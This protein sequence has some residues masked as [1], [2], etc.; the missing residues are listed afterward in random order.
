MQTRTSSHLKGVDVSSHQGVIDWNKMKAAGVQ[1]AILRA[2]GSNHSTGG[3]TRMA[4]YVAGARAVGIPVG[5][6]FF[7]WINNPDDYV[8]ARRQANLYVDKLESVFGAGKWGDLYPFIDL[9]GNENV[10]QN[11]IYG[12]HSSLDTTKMLRWV[13]EFRKQFESRLNV[14]LGIY[15]SHYF[16]YGYHKH[17]NEGVT[18]E[19]NILKNMPL[20]IA[21]WTSSTTITDAGGWTKWVLWQ[22]S[23]SGDAYG[24]GIAHGAQSSGLDIDVG[25]PLEYL[26]PPLPPSNAVG[27]L[28]DNKYVTLTWTKSPDNDIISYHI[29]RNGTKIGTVSGTTTSFTDNAISPNVSYSYY[30]QA[31]DEY[32]GFASSNTV[33]IQA[34]DVP[35]SV[36]TGLTVT[37]KDREI[38]FRWTANT[39]T[40][41]KQYNLYMGG[42]FIAS[43]PDTTYTKTGLTNGVV[44]SFQVEAERANGKKS[45]LSAAVQG[46]PVLDVPTKVTNVNASVQTDK[47]IL[48]TWED[49]PKANWSH[50]Q[51][52]VNNKIVAN[53]ISDT[54]FKASGLTENATLS[55]QV[56]SVD[57]QGDTTVSDTVTSI[58]EVPAT[59]TGFVATSGDRQITITW[60]AN[61][62]TFFRRYNIYLDNTLLASTTNTSYTLSNLVNGRTYTFAVAAESLSGVSSNRTLPI[63]ATP[64]A[65][66][67]KQPYQVKA[68]VESASVMVLSWKDEPKADFSHYRIYKNDMLLADNVTVK[69][70]RDTGI[71][72]PDVT[73]SYVVS[74]VD[75]DGDENKSTPVTAIIHVPA[76]PTELVATPYDREISLSWKSSTDNWFS[77]Y[78]VYVNGELYRTITDHAITIEELTNDVV[79][80]FKVEA[81][82]ETGIV[83][84]PS[85]IVSAIPK[86]DVPNKPTI[87]SYETTGIGGVELIWEHEQKSPFEHYRV[88]QNGNILEDYITTKSYATPPLEPDV[89]HTFHVETIDKHGDVSGWSDSVRAIVYS[90]EALSGGDRPLRLGEIDRS[91]LPIEPHLYLCKP[92]KTTIASLVEAYNIELTTK[93]ADLNEIS[94]SLPYYIDKGTGTKRNP[95]IDAIRERFLLKLVLGDKTE[96]FI[97]TQISDQSDESDTKEIRAWS[98][99]YELRDKVIRNLKIDEPF[100]AKMAMETALTDVLNWSIGENILNSNFN[101]NRETRV[102]DVSS[103]T[104]L[105][106]VKQ[107]AESYHATIVWDTVNRIID[108]KNP[109]LEDENK[110]LTFS[111][112]KYLR[113]LGLQRSSEDMVT[114]LTP[115]GAEGITIQEANPTGSLFLENFSHFLFPFERDV[116]RNIIQS[117]NYMSDSLAH[118]ILDYQALLETHEGEYKTL[119]RDKSIK[120]ADITDKEIELDEATNELVIAQDL[121]DALKAQNELMYYDVAY[122]GVT[123]TFTTQLKDAYHYVVIGKVVNPTN[124]T[125]SIDDVAKTITADTWTVLAKLEKPATVPTDSWATEIT[126]SGTGSTSVEVQVN[127]ILATEYTDLTDDELLDKYSEEIHQREVDTLTNELNTLKIELTDI[128]LQIQS[129]VSTLSIEN[130]FT[131]AQR[132]ERDLFV[133][134]KDWTN[135]SLATSEEL[136]EAAKK[137]FEK[138]LEPQIV[139]QINVVNFLNVLEHQ[140]D[141]KKLVLGDIVTIKHDILGLEPTKAK[142][143]EITYSFDNNDIQLTI[144]NV[145]DIRNDEQKFI[146]SLYGAISTS[147]TVDVEKYKWSKAEENAIALDN[148]FNQAIDATKQKIIAGVNETV[149]ISNRGLLIRDKDDPNNYLVGQHAVLA[150]TNDGGKTFKNAITT[151]GVIGERIIGEILAGDNLIIKN[152]SGTFTVDANGVTVDGSAFNI[153]GG[154]SNDKLGLDWSGLRS[155]YVNYTDENNKIS[156]PVTVPTVPADSI[157]HT[158]NADGSVNISFQWNFDDTDEQAGSIDGFMIYIHQSTSSASYSFG[159]A[160]SREVVYNVS[161]SKRSIILKN[162][163]KQVYYTFGVESYRTVDTTVN[164]SGVI[165]S[166]IVKS[167][168]VAENPYNPSLSTAFTGD[169]EGTIPSVVTNTNVTDSPLRYVQLGADYN[170]VKIDANAGIVVT[171]S[172]GKLRTILNATDGIAI[173]QYVNNAWTNKFFADA[174]GQLYSR[175]LVA[176]RLQIKDQ[177]G[178]VL[179]DANASKINFGSFGSHTGTVKGTNL[180]LKGNTVN[181][182]TADTFKVD[183]NGNV[184]IR[185]NITMEGGSITWA[186]ITAPSYTQVTG[187]KPPTDANNTYKELNPA[188]QTSAIKGFYFNAATNQLEINADYITVGSV[189]DNR[190]ASASSWNSAVTTINNM[191]NDDKLTPVEKQTIKRQWATIVA[192]KPNYVT[193]AT[194]Y[195]VSSTAYVNAYNTLDSLLNNTTNGYLLNM[196]TT[197]DLGVGGG[198]TFRDKFDDYYATL[199]ALTK[200]INEEAKELAD[201]AQ[202]TASSAQSAASSAQGTA[203]TASSNASSALTKIDVIQKINNVATGGILTAELIK[204]T[205]Y[206]GSLNAGEIQIKAVAEDIFVHPDGT[207]YPIQTGKDI[208]TMYEGTSTETEGYIMFVGSDEARFTIT[209]VGSTKQFVVTKFSNGNWY[210]DNNS[211]S[212][213]VFTVTEKDCIVGKIIRTATS[214]GIDTL[215]LF[216]GRNVATKDAVESAQSTASSAQSTASSA[217][218]TANTAIENA[219][220]AQSTANTAIGDASTAQE[221]ANNALGEIAVIQKLYNVVMGGIYTGEFIKNT[222]YNGTANAGEIQIKIDAE[223]LFVHPDGTEYAIAINK[224]IS[225]HLEGTG[226]AEEAYIMFTGYDETRFT[227]GTTVASKQFVLAKYIDDMWHYDDNSTTWRQFT[228]TDKDCIVAKVLKS[229][230]SAEIDSIVLYA[231]RNVATKTAVASVKETAEGAHEKIDNLEVGG[232]NYIRDADFKDFSTT[233]W[234]SSPNVTKDETVL[235]QGYPT[236]KSA[237]S[238]L[239]APA[240][241]GL[242]QYVPFEIGKEYTFSVYIMT[243]NYTAIDVPSNIQIICENPDGSVLQMFEAPIDFA[244]NGGNNVWVRF[245][246]TALIPV[247]TSKVR[248]NARVYQNGTMWFALPQYELGNKMTDWTLA[249]EDVTARLDAVKETAESAEST[250]STVNTTVTNNQ[251]TWDRAANFNTNGT[252]NTTKLSGTVSDNQVASA[253]TWHSKETPEGAQAKVDAL[254]IGGRNLITNSTVNKKTDGTADLTNWS[255]FNTGASALTTATGRLDDFSAQITASQAQ[256]GVRTPE[257]TK[258]MGGEEYVASVWIKQSTAGSVGFL[259]KF[260]DANGAETNPIPTATVTCNANEWVRVVQI[261]TMPTTA[262][263]CDLTARTIT[264]TYPV[265]L[266]VDDAQIEKGNKVTDWTLSIEDVN[267]SIATAESNAK[268]YTD[269]LSTKGLGLKVNYS[270]FATTNAGELYVH[271]FDSNGNPADVDGYLIVNGEKMTVP[272]GQINPNSAIGEAYITYS[273]GSNKWMLSYVDANKVWKYVYADGTNLGTIFT[274]NDSHY[275]V[276]VADVTGAETIASATLWIDYKTH[277]EMASVAEAKYSNST[278][279]SNKG[280]WDR[281]TNINAD[282]TFNT[283]KLSG[284]VSDAQIAS[285]A[286]WNAKETTSGAQAKADQARK[287]ALEAGLMTKNPLFFDWSGNYPVGMVAWSTG[288]GQKETVITRNGGNALRFV[289]TGTEDAGARYKDLYKANLANVKYVVV[290]FDFYVVS[291]TDLSAAGFLIDWAGMSPYRVMMNLPSIYSNIEIGKW[292]SVRRVIQRPTDTLT[293]F[294]SMDGYLMAS[295]TTLGTKAPK[296]IVYDRFLVREATNEEIKAYESANTLTLL[297]TTEN[298]VT[299]IDG[300]KIKT[301][302]VDVNVIKAGQ[303]HV[304][305]VGTNINGIVA[306]GSI[307]ADIKINT[308]YANT[309]NAGEIY[310][311]KG[312]YIAPNGQI[313]YFTGGTTE[314]DGEVSTLFEGATADSVGIGYLAYVGSDMSR[315]VM[316]SGYSNTKL[317]ILRPNGTEWQYQNNSTW[318]SFVPNANDFIIAR[319]ERDAIVSNGIDRIYFYASIAND[320]GELLDYATGETL[321]I[322]GKLTNNSIETDHLQAS[323]VTVE[324]LD[325]RARD[326]INNPSRTETLTGWYPIN[327]T[328]GATLTLADNVDRN[329]KVMKLTSTDRIDAI[330][331]YFEVD[332]LDT[333]KFTAS[334]YHPNTTGATQVRFYCY[335]KNKAALSTKYYDGVTRAYVASST[336]AWTYYRTGA[337]SETDTLGLFRPVELYLIGTDVDPI[338]TPTGIN[339]GRIIQ[340]PSNAKFVRI[341]VVNYNNGGVSGD[342][343]VHSPTMKKVDAGIFTFD[344]AKGGTLSLGGTNN[345]NGV[346]EVLSPDGD[347]QVTLAGDTGGF[348]SLFIGEIRG[349]NVVTRNNK[350]ALTY[351]VDPV[352]G[353]DTNTGTDTSPFKTMQA[354]IN[355]IP[356]VNDDD[357]NIQVLGTGITFVESLVI[358]GILGSGRILISLGQSNKMKGEISVL[359]CMNEVNIATRQSSNVSTANT[360]TLRAEIINQNVTNGT[361]YAHTCQAVIAN[362]IVMNGNNLIAYGI[363]AIRSY[364]RATYCECYNATAGGAIAQFGSRLEIENCAGSN[365]KGILVAHSSVAGG[366][367]RGFY[368]ASTG[369]VTVTQGGTCSATWTHDAGASKPTYAPITTSTWTANKTYSYNA[370]TGWAS[371]YVYQGKRPGDIPIWYG[372]FFFDTASF[373]VLKNA[374]GTA[375]PI[376]SVRV[377]IQRTSNTGDNTARKPKFY[378]NMQTTASGSVQTLQTSGT[379]AAESFLWGEEKWVVL[380][381]SFGTA[382]QNGTAKSLVIYYGSDEA[383]YMRFEAKATLEI[384]HG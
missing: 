201:T 203:N 124:V 154:V 133:I 381:T 26:R 339:Q 248:I 346:L 250:A 2:Y 334:L 179:I 161:R 78:R 241:R 352:A 360:S 115:Y 260:R 289:T 76:K 81:V 213:T 231:S 195:G 208:T 120:Q 94:F 226:F 22:I 85:D 209:T 142:I 365:P 44:Y 185:G 225:T 177:N 269:K 253:T 372:F 56:A 295:Y 333:Y 59:P 350:G 143:I 156:V 21:R 68:I 347:K 307:L 210:Y 310:I 39:E 15:T 325:V 157:D 116:N 234:S 216:A 186:N 11:G 318:L 72:E 259:L 359:Y 139:I 31:E 319:I 163:P 230:T 29:Y 320:L 87:V 27:T 107:I 244:N 217:Q 123:Q 62:E 37:A 153:I 149:E 38:E 328:T 272:K 131:E 305:N 277:I 249:I 383:N 145:E 95:N 118:A 182:G 376:N 89:Q 52:I 20:W 211:G 50:Y 57:T 28:K 335:D 235:F 275:F 294:T 375:R 317:A 368:G 206:D 245:V 357:I 284:T 100:T 61:L 263:E 257:A 54:T 34:V 90:A 229:A 286:T 240:Y 239:A 108:F 256:A 366:S 69:T 36:P 18:A 111:Y 84:E 254:E 40:D 283:T 222:T 48:I 106:F 136:Y 16:I 214:S 70:Y 374:D 148:F 336:S 268:T 341:A 92:N 192:E 12:K 103:Q 315:I 122:A 299:V 10:S 308:S 119:Q 127:R 151:T 369:H 187:T 172:S 290:E 255:L 165:K 17:F 323:A 355:V 196:A 193:L 25:M 238:G 212:W 60:N 273:K 302:S 175:D 258:L 252:L 285:A 337:T 43:T 329:A 384:V 342:T 246:V 287:E 135:S 220:T 184:T 91:L 362:D 132:K 373:S 3:D 58:I 198:A 42:T 223:D 86:L 167:A 181:N 8:E 45:A 205:R 288:K 134:N 117:S 23:D 271:G 88:Y 338:K 219:S 129:L 67:P 344:Q 64:E 150:I 361:V 138:L 221:T 158:N 343:F 309:A 351:Y 47:S 121:L 155:S 202:G 93:L 297:T 41:I 345:Q 178:N 170:N 30:I 279:S 264:G 300:G 146:E 358:R 265:T 101:W 128:D 13:D 331:D 363:N 189:T 378:Y 316:S 266:W 126:I 191:A 321:I 105:E 301:N 164:A 137:E 102:F 228:V 14:S 236:I 168:T 281:A 340:L 159:T 377:K 66:L 293:G 207:V 292:Y 130:N 233:Y 199:S 63:H 356:K 278:I 194:T 55:I 311:G 304:G 296:D 267:S 190:I 243:D 113:S 174:N 380:P 75:T 71:L 176:E 326:L 322:G 353:L 242:K 160:P 65:V 49:A 224:E 74:S 110:G 332:A 114:R 83:S 141:W 364:V 197:T 24:N 218:A 262:V 327:G 282:G 180:D 379:V 173:Q 73:Y 371:T 169:I 314:N 382:F 79:Y 280:T 125:L 140:S 96:Y 46:T 261:F 35:P 291:G 237:Q 274:P 270:A 51:V 32:R 313:V 5:S 324:K 77:Y 152:T 330:T 4:E 188:T 276:G 53:F 82:S 354:A 298:N 367:G 33:A 204:N 171:A 370:N 98:L 97:I 109:A 306:G 349:N 99:G 348:D 183:I 6:Y 200:N 227:M 166:A 9:E 232:R 303:L 247:G 144:A 80:S 19:G 112:G 251:A 1:F 215:T 7:C 147:I 104:V 162:V 312:K